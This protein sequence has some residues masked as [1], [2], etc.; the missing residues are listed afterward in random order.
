ML[1]RP[2]TPPNWASGLAR[3]MPE[4]KALTDKQKTILEFVELYIGKNGIPP[5]RQEIADAFEFQSANAAQE[6]LQAIAKKGWLKIIKSAV[7]N[8]RVSRGLQ[9]L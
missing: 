6:H 5:T 9:L 4:K 8:G 7:G 3:K 2:S 1:S